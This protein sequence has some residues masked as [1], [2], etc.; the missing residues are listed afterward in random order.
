MS[1]VSCFRDFVFEDGRR[2]ESW[3]IAGRDLNGRILAEISADL[4]GPLLY[5]ECSEA[6]KIVHVENIVFSNFA[7]RH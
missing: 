1:N 6:A 2:F 7:V 3:D 4:G 5:E